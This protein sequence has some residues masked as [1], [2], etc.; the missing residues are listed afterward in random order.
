M[1]CESTRGDFRWNITFDCAKLGVLTNDT[2]G[3][4]QVLSD[5][6]DAIVCPNP[7]GPTD[8][9]SYASVNKRLEAKE[10]YPGVEYV[11]ARPIMLSARPQKASV[12]SISQG[13]ELNLYIEEVGDR[14]SQSSWSGVHSASSMYVT[15][16]DGT[17][18]NEFGETKAPSYNQVSAE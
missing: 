7:Q 16:F 3:G 9:H 13:S 5:I 6:E 2:N 12:F 14:N 17:S 11:P 1:N 15:L 4:V 10:L 18:F 8:P